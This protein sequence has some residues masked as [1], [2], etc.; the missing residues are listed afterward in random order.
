MRSRDAQKGEVRGENRDEEE[1]VGGEKRERGRDD[2]SGAKGREEIGVAHGSGSEKPW[3]PPG[4]RRERDDVAMSNPPT[5]HLFGCASW[6]SCGPAP[7]RSVRAPLEEMMQPC[8]PTYTSSLCLTYYM[9]SL[10]LPYL[11]NIS[12]V[13][14]RAGVEPPPT[15]MAGQGGLA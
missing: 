8:L 2:A 6:A 7:P 4:R 14:R 11:H 12:L 3:A 15:P 1:W 13:A 10:C 9:S 5:Y